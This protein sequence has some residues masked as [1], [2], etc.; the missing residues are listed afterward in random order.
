MSDRKSKPKPRDLIDGSP[1]LFG[2]QPNARWRQPGT[3]DELVWLRHAE[4]Q[5]EF[6]F[7]VRMHLRDHRL[8]QA[9]FI[10]AAKGQPEDENWFPR[11]HFGRGINGTA[12]FTL[13]Q[14]LRI[15][16]HTGP[17]LARLKFKRTVLTSPA[18]IEAHPY[19]ASVDHDVYRRV[20]GKP[21]PLSDPQSE[22]GR[23][24][25]RRRA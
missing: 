21:H 18:L 15:E 16:Q 13:D 8:S 1:E 20:H 10:G 19:A 7:R 25:P 4:I 14:M 12:W 17:I 2:F 24:A 11:D 9:R 22:P 23:A 6:A 3:L 5:H